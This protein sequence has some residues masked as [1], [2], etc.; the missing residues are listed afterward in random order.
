MGSALFA[1][2]FDRFAGKDEER[3]QADLR[4]ELLAGLSGVVVEIGPGNGLNF[5]HYPPAV[6]AVVAV[7]PQ[8]HLRRRAAETA[9]GAPV[10]IRVVGGS[11]DR[12]PLSDGLAD[13]VV[14]SGVLC[15]VPDQRAA[16]AELGRVLVPGGE[17]RFYEHVRGSGPFGRYQDAV[18]PVWSRLMGGCRLNRDTRTAIERSGYR[19]EVCRDLRF[20]PQARFSPVAPRVIG[21]ARRQ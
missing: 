3:G 9:R 15:S 17:L 14:V 16:L 10:D 20:P 12:I 21:V 19:I 8:P 13:A 4:R 18:A 6:R 7:E 11:A 5:P 1:R 2:F